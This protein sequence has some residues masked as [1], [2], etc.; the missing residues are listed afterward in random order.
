MRRRSQR[1]NS[2][3]ATPPPSSSQT[4]GE[5]PI[6]CGASGLGCT[7]PHVPDF[8]IPNTISP[9]PSDDSAVPNRSSLTPFSAGVSCT[10]RASSRITATINTSPANTHRQ[11][12]YVVNAPP[13]NGPSA[14]AIA[15]AAATRPYARGRSDLPKFDAT[16][17]TIAGM[18]STAPRPSR[19]DQPIS[20]TVRFGAS[21]VVIDPQAYTMQP[22]PNARLRPTISPTLPPVI[23]SDAITSV[24]IVI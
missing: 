15:P 13:T 12:A 17:A 1:R 9:R 7:T 14:A 10:R 24:Y 22:R 20:R 23:I 2:A 6:Q 18:I 19:P 8:R 5:R 3:S 16:S 11:E 4:T 21:A